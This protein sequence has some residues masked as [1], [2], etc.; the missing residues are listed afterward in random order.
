[1]TSIGD[2]A[3]GLGRAQAEVRHGRG[4]AAARRQAQHRGPLREGRL[5]EGHG[6]PPTATKSAKRSSISAVSAP[7]FARKYA[8]CSIFQNLQDYLTELFENIIGNILQFLQDHFAK[9]SEFS[10]KLLIFQTAFLLKF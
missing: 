3:R 5:D 7:I 10:R 8:F 4:L 1:M 6:E 2:F 9:N